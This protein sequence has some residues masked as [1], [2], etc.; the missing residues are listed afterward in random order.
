VLT[1]DVVVRLQAEG[2][3][4][5]GRVLGCREKV[6]SCSLVSIANSCDM[7]SILK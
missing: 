5:N 1:E 6:S 4:L 7:L 3:G 2:A